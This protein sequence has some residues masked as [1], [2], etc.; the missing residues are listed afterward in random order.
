MVVSTLGIWGIIRKSKFLTGLYGFVLIV[1]ILAQV[2]AIVAPILATENA[3]NVLEKASYKTLSEWNGKNGKISKSWDA[4]QNK[5]NCCGVRGY[6]DWLNSTTF[7]ENQ[8]PEEVT[9][10]IAVP[11]SCCISYG[12]KCGLTWQRMVF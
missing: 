8:N 12:I 7:Q 5:L 9:A 11:D 6:S 1:L 3:E 4:I 10:P 2:L